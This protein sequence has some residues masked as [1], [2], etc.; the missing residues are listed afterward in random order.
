MLTE[1]STGGEGDARE[2]WRRFIHVPPHLLREPFGAGRR[3]A[4]RKR[5]HE[6]VASV[7]QT[8]DGIGWQPI[9][10]MRATVRGPPPRQSDARRRH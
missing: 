4:A 7:A 9:G 6:L 1:R 10:K 5:D 8:R 2:D 3:T